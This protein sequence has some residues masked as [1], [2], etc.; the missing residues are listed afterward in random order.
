MTLEIIT[1]KLPVEEVT[2]LLLLSYQQQLATCPTHAGRQILRR[3]IGELQN[4]HY[5]RHPVLVKLF[6]VEAAA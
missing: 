1:E 3:K 4:P 6:F 5:L 2:Q